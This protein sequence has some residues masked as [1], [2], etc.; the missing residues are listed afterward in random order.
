MP[1]PNYTLSEALTQYNSD[2]VATANMW[3][4]QAMNIPE[5]S[6]L[7]VM[8]IY[9]K[10]FTIPNRTNE[11]EDVN[12]RGYPIPTP[13]TMKMENQHSMNIV[14]D[15]AGLLREGFLAW[16]ARAIQPGITGNPPSFGADRRPTD[17]VGKANL[18]LNL[19]AP[20]YSTVLTKVTMHGVR[21]SEV[22]GYQLSNDNG[23]IATFSVQFRSVYWELENTAGT[24]N[25]SEAAISGPPANAKY[26]ATG[27]VAV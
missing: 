9:A 17:G 2:Q 13:T 7:H 5:D 16:Q 25:P 8:Q 22:G 11:F 14:A 20:D 15:V 4:I 10:D 27:S 24:F 6:V 1:N 18:V 23:S 26:E 3:Y 12:Y 21:V 19:L